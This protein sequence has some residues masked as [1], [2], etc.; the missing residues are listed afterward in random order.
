MRRGR[1]ASASE[2]ASNAPGHSLGERV[3]DSALQRARDDV[4]RTLRSSTLHPDTTELRRV[5]RRRRPPEWGEP[6]APVAE[7]LR[8]MAE[9]F[10]APTPDTPVLPTRSFFPLLPEFIEFDYLPDDEESSLPVHIRLPRE[11]CEYTLWLLSWAFNWFRAG[12]EPVPALPFLLRPDGG[13]SL[14][15]FLP[16][17]ILH[18]VN[19]GFPHPDGASVASLPA[20]SWLS[21][22]SILFSRCSEDRDRRLEAVDLPYGGRLYVSVQLDHRCSI[23]IVGICDR[24][25]SEAADAAFREAFQ[26]TG[27]AAFRCRWT[28]ATG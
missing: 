3:G 16:N 19:R 15:A 5:P 28:D 8:G 18:A 9:G 27:G 11:A 6:L 4:A 2:R 23:G 13:P 25:G 17:R 20:G 14:E 24:L 22:R 12:F 1:R 10:L 7:R 21:R 26:Q